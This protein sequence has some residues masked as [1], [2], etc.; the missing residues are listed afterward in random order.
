MSPSLG[1]QLEGSNNNTVTKYISSQAD[2]SK[3]VESR[4]RGSTIQIF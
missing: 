4:D 3:R 1:L 2:N